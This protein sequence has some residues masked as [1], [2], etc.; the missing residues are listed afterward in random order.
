MSNAFINSWPN[1]HSTRQ[2]RI[3][4]DDFVSVEMKYTTMCPALD[5]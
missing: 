2:V 5:C 4:L 3:V 1:S